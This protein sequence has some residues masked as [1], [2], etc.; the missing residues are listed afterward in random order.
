[1]KGLLL[2]SPIYE[3]RSN[4]EEEYLPPLGLGYIATHLMASG[5][6]VEIIDCVKERFGVEEIFD[7]LRRE[8]PEY[9]GINVFTQ[10]YEIVKKIVE[11]CPVT[12]RIIIGGQVIKYIYSEVLKWNIKNELILIIGEGELLLPAILNGSCC[13]AP[14]SDVPGKTVYRVN[15]NSNYF[16]RDLSFVHFDRTLLKGS[17]VTNHYYEKESSIITSRGCMYN[18]TFCGGSRNLNRDV[19]IRYR[20]I[21]DVD[22]EI[23]EIITAHPE[24][25]SIRVLDDLFLRN[26]TSINNAIEMFRNYTTI[27]W[28]GMAHVLTF[29]TSKMLDTLQ[30]LKISGCREL[31]IGIESGSE[32]M[33]KK[34]NK[35]GTVE[36]VIKVITA[37]LQEGIDVKGYFMYGFLNETVADA[38]ATYA[39]A[40][41]LKDIAQNTKAKFRVS[42]FQ[43]RPYHGTQLYN[44]IVES[45]QTIHPIR[46]ND[47]LNIVSGRSQFNFQSGNYSEIED[48]I[49]SKYILDTQN[50]SDVAHV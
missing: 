7:L 50:L 40:S 4:V 30:Q 12:A 14:V 31:F 2:N 47:T 33:R 25:V 27:S 15:K 38:N 43:F 29:V 46:S 35:P 24:V 6:D 41:R 8:R 18:C 13:E 19:A 26:G 37:I 28:R 32:R 11:N 5:I 16:P 44:E 48:N 10:N 36:Q 1:M 49:L 34:I 3:I 39:L 23:R 22:C 17:V 9:I 42:V 20:N 21:G 45:G